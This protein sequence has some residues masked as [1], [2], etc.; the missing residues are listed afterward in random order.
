MKKYYTIYAKMLGDKTHYPMCSYRN[1]I[2]FGNKMCREYT[3]DDFDVAVEDAEKALRELNDPDISV[4]VET[5][6]DCENEYGETCSIE[7]VMITI[8]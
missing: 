6:E 5:W 7:D 3:T 2:Y 1:Q 8:E 4:Y